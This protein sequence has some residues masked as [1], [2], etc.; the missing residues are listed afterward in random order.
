MRT[1]NY[2]KDPLAYLP[3]LSQQV[4]AVPVRLLLCEETHFEART[5][6]ALWSL[7]QRPG[8]CVKLAGFQKQ[9]PG[10]P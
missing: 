3:A 9:R 4:M 2:Q 8:F 5:Y 6:R 10:M 7:C 1:F